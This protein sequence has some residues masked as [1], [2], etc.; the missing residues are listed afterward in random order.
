MSIVTKLM[1]EALSHHHARHWF[2]EHDA[3]NVWH[4]DGKGFAFDRNNSPIPE[5]VARNLIDGEPIRATLESAM[6]RIRFT[7]AVPSDETEQLVYSV[8]YGRSALDLRFDLKS[9]DKAAELVEM[10]GFQIDSIDLIVRG[11]YT[12]KLTKKNNRSIERFGSAATIPLALVAAALPTRF[13]Q[14]RERAHIA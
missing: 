10:I 13:Q 7:S 1:N 4:E 12:V 8:V 9:F 3:I 6:G 2:T 11:K 14:L 5:D